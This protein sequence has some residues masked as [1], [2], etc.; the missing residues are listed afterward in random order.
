MAG[1]FGLF[2]YEKEGRGVYPDEPP[3]GA[4]LTFFSILGRKFWKICT[5]NIMY[6]LLSA[7]A[8]VLAFFAAPLFLQSMLPSL[9]TDFL[10]QVFNESGVVLK[11]G[12]TLLEYVSYQMSQM[13][14]VTAI[15]LVGLS[16]II[17][18]PVHA[19]VV[20][21]L[22]NYAREE[23]AFVWMDFKEHARKNWKQSL[24][25]SLISLLFLVIF[26]FNYA[27]YDGSNLVQSDL[28]RIVLKTAMVLAFVIWC[29]M[30]MYI[31]PM[32]VTFQLSLKQLLKNSLLF[33]LIRLPF[34]VLIL[35]LSFIILCAFPAIMLLLGY[36]FSVFVAIIWYACFALAFNLYLT[37]FFAWR[38]LDRFM[39]QRVEEEETSEAS[40]EASATDEPSAEDEDETEEEQPSKEQRQKDWQKSPNN[41]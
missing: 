25:V 11:E 13:Y 14:F 19:G 22:R 2:N 8:F 18:A 32:M 40:D 4:F 34:N 30:Q 26:I 5:I 27:F 9:S 29:I 15:L 7:P 39:L 17:V 21:L 6:V 38:G 20:F 1:F 35:L 10:I 3:K 24:G 23:H 28:L 41:A 16:L 33:T 12:V 37:T 31:Y 36:G